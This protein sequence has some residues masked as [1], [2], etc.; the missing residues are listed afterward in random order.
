MH[1]YIRQNFAALDSEFPQDKESRAI[2]L[3]LGSTKFQVK[4]ILKCSTYYAGILYID[5]HRYG[6]VT[7][8]FDDD[9]TGSIECMMV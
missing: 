5:I 7:Q 1:G 2:S 9:A 8:T 4:T 6:S 3:T